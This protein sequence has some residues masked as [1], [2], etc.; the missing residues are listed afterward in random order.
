MAA[1]TIED[2]ELI[3]R[4]SGISYQ[5]AVALLGIYVIYE[6]LLAFEVIG[7]AVRFIRCFTIFK[8]RKTGFHSGRVNAA[9]GM[10]DAAVHIHLY[11]MG[12]EFYLVIVNLAA[13]VK[14]CVSATRPHH[15]V[16]T[17]VVYGVFH[18]VAA[19]LFLYNNVIANVCAVC[20]K[21]ESENRRVSLSF[22]RAVSLHR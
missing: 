17:L 14:V 4:K 18:R 22:M 11:D 1:Y 15:G 19:L 6:A 9:S 8:D 2:I 10:H 7:N 16:G 5:E 13:T 20:K 21:N 3:R 12:S